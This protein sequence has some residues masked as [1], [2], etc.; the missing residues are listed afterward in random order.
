MKDKTI[1]ALRRL[2]PWAALLV[3]FAGLAA[4]RG[5]SD[6]FTIDYEIMNGDFQNYNPVRHL[7]AG[8]APYA[9]FTVYLGAG[10]LYGVAALLAVLG[11]NF[12]NSIFAAEFLTWFCFELLAL[13]ACRA[14]FVSGRAA[15]AAAAAVTDDNDHDGVAKA[16]ERY[17]LGTLAEEPPVP[18]PAR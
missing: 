3:L 17:I 11:N 2:A 4:L 10:E 6:S 12:A 18:S 9:D 8:Q 15:R 1:C 5:L 14:V 13:A 7:L 16:I